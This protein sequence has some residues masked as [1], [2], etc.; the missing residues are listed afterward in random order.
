MLWW[1]LSSGDKA[2]L[3]L[4]P[5]R[6]L[7]DDSCLPRSRLGA[8]IECPAETHMAFLHGLVG[9]TLVKWLL[10]LLNLFLRPCKRHLLLSNKYCRLSLI[11]A[12]AYKCTLWV[13]LQ[14]SK[15]PWV[16]H[17]ASPSKRGWVLF[18]ML[19]YLT[20]K[21][22]PCHVYSD[23]MPSKQIIGQTIVYNGATR[24]WRPCVKWVA[25]LLTS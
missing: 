5:N 7:L 8:R 1:G 14:R 3:L 16:E 19:T 4:A 10:D 25:C 22:C 12:C 2:C 24:D 21:E 9:Q 15:C 13:V 20:M 17:R 6:N 18:R 11:S 23:S